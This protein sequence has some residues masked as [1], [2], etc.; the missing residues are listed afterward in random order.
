MTSWSSVVVIDRGKSSGV[1]PE[2]AVIT[3]AGLAGKVIES[4]QSTSKVMLLNDPNMSVSAIIQ[5]SRQEGLVCGSWNSNLLIMRYL[6][7]DT[8]IKA[9]DVI[10]ASGFSPVYPKGLLIGVVK[11]VG[12]ELSG[13]SLYAMVKPQVQ[14]NALEEVMVVV[15]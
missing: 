4:G 14:L 13:L 7:F 15:K 3:S 1:K 10:I 6:S 9:G 8:D 5:R 2:M 11:E 12:A